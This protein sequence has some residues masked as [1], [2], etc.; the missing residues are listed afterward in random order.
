M[1]KYTTR[2]FEMVEFSEKVYHA[3]L[4]HKSINGALYE[5]LLI[6]YLREDVPE[7]SFYKG[8]IDNGHNSRSSQMDVIVCRKDTPELDF[9]KQVSPFVNL[10]PRKDCLGV[11]ELKKWGQPSMIR[12]NGTINDAYDKF[13]AEYPELKFLFVSFRYKDRKHDTLN[14]WHT[15]YRELKADGAYPFSGRVTNNE[16]E[17][18]SDP[19]LNFHKEYFGQYERLVNDLKGLLKKAEA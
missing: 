13:K 11:I 19:H 15:L 16:W 9:I 12:H 3:G 10:V 6:T 17:P 5:D 1:N 14:N 4:R 8:Q 7:L 18:W 2:Q